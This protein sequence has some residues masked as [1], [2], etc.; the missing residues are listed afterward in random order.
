M[1]IPIILAYILLKNFSCYKI[2]VG[3][4]GVGKSYIVNLLGCPAK[5]CDAS[6]SCTKQALICQNEKLIDTMGLDDDE[7]HDIYY[8][9]NKIKLSGFIYPLYNLFEAL[10]KY[11]I[12]EAE[13]FFVYDSNNIREG[14]SSQALKNFLKNELKCP[15]KRVLNKYRDVHKSRSSSNDILIYENSHETNL[16][17]DLSGIPC[18]FGLSNDW[19]EKLINQDLEGVRSQIDVVKCNNLK[20][21][22]KA[23][24]AILDKKEK[25]WDDRECSYNFYVKTICISPGLF[26]GCWENKPIYDKRT[27]N[28][29]VIR[30]DAMNKII[31]DRINRLMKKKQKYLKLI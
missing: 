24:D 7:S 30:R 9:G 10:E 1:K 15:F 12:N 16:R 13:F 27:D 2:F 11:S 14:Q 3:R 26:W 6:E 18:T 5:S 8:K 29:C 4:T 25:A 19:R 21:T 22:K 31:L 20:A 23:Y 28:D 17:K